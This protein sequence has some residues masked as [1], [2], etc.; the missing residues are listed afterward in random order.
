LRGKHLVLA[1]V[2]GNNRF[3]FGQFE[4]FVDD[5]LRFDDLVILLV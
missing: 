5:I 1:D 2:S 3:M 4:E